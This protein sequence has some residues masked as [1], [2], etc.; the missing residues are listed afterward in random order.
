MTDRLRRRAVWIGLLGLLLLGPT[1]AASQAQTRPRVAF[2]T[3]EGRFIVELYPEKAP[4]T[5]KNFLR[6]VREGFYDG[7]IFHRVISG[8]VIQGGGYTAEYELKP[9]RPPIVNEADNGLPNERGT[10]S[11]AR[12][13][14][15]HSA[16]SQFF[17]NLA[18]NDTL[19][20]RSASYAGAGYA[21][22]GKVVQGMETI[23][24]IAHAQTGPAGPFRGDAPQPAI[25]ILDAQ[26]QQ[27]GSAD[28]AGQGG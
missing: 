2:N 14:D 19:N 13:R 18:D 27:A 10:L 28:A 15:P 16:T 25:V 24:E 8:F 1:L 21:V 26:V 4:K 12:T 20:R 3:S 9:T 17:I 6:Y 23:D 7:T 11:M 22:F 5:A